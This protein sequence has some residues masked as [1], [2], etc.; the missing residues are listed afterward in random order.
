MDYYTLSTTPKQEVS[1]IT[2]FTFS[3]VAIFALLW[4]LTGMVAFVYSLFCFTRSGTTADKIL[5]VIIAWFLGP[6][7]FLYPYFNQAYCKKLVI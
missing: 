5:G 4:F 2:Y 3:F 1:P 7:F 6:F